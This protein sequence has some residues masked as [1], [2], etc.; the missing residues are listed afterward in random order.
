MEASKLHFLCEGYVHFNQ[1]TQHQL[2][3]TGKP[4]SN[5]TNSADFSH[6]EG[7]PPVNLLDISKFR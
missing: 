4:P 2:T 6:L 5:F 7:K 1:I 3:L